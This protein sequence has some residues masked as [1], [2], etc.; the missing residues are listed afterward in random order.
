MLQMS[1]LATALAGILGIA[2]PAVA[3]LAAERATTAPAQSDIAPSAGIPVA[4]VHDQ[5]YPP[6]T[7]ARP[8]R[9]KHR[10]H[11]ANVVAVVAAPKPAATAP[12]IPDGPQL[13]VDVPSAGIVAHRSPWSSSPKTGVVAEEAEALHR[14]VGL[15][16]LSHRAECTGSRGLVLIREFFSAR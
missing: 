7:V 6:R 11:P 4:M 3:H 14:N 5:P 9:P 12:A 10:R 1:W 15:D 2:T 16:S 8:D 13:L